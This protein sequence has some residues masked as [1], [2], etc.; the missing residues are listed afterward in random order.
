MRA[1]GGEGHVHEHVQ[2]DQLSTVERQAV[3]MRMSRLGGVSVQEIRQVHP[4]VAL[5]TKI[6]P[7][8]G[9]ELVRRTHRPG[10]Q[11]F[12]L[13]THPPR[14]GRPYPVNAVKSFTMPGAVFPPHHPA[15]RSHLQR[16]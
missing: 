13:L 16:A 5:D 8:R 14:A 4:H 6:P 3:L 7:M 9:S 11:D 12:P 1:N 15:T 10:G 2:P